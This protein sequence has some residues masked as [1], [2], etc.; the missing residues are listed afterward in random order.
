MVITEA[1]MH[2]MLDLIKLASTALDRCE[3][4][5]DDTWKLCIKEFKYL[6]DEETFLQ[7]LQECEN[8]IYLDIKANP[9]N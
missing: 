1:M 9:T 8:M 2:S 3:P 4:D 6:S 5:L 7:L